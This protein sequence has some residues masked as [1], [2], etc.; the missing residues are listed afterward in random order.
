MQT[1]PRRP[2]SGEADLCCNRNLVSVVPSLG[3]AMRRRD[4]IKVVTGS[5]MAWPLAAHAQQGERM[6]LIG[7]LMGWPES[8]PAA[9]SSRRSGAHLQSYTG[10]KVAISGSNFA[11]VTLIQLKLVRSQKSWSICDPMQSLERPRP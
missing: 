8:Y 1:D 4:F 6:R 2:I 7:V 5:A 9:L 11:R 3:K 10:L